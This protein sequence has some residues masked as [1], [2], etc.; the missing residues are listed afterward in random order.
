MMLAIW[1][2]FSHFNKNLITSGKVYE[3]GNLK[4]EGNYKDWRVKIGKWEYYD[5]NGNFQSS[6]DYGDKGSIEEVQEYYDRGEISYGW[7]LNLTL[8][9]PL[10]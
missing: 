3:N 9:F 8:R 10:C 6:I 5:Q 7:V 2:G 1:K 4:A